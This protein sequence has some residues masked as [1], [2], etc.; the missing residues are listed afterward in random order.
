MDTN[1]KDFTVVCSVSSYVACDTSCKDSCTGPGPLKYVECASGYEMSEHHFCQDVD[2]CS[3]GEVECEEGTYCANKLG[4]YRCESECIHRNPTEA[5]TLCHQY[6]HHLSIHSST[7]P[8]HTPFLPSFSLSLRG[9]RA[10]SDYSTPCRSLQHY[11]CPLW[12]SS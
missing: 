5:S 1:I 11:R 4:S 6:I 12:H 9:C 10:R 2:E 3:K 8:T 7:H